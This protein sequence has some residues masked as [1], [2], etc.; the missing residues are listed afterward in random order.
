MQSSQLRHAFTY[1]V[2]C[3]G[4]YKYIDDLIRGQYQNHII[5]NGKFVFLDGDLVTEKPKLPDVLAHLPIG[6]ILQLK[7]YAELPK[8][9]RHLPDIVTPLEPYVEVN[10]TTKDQTTTQT[11]ICPATLRPYYYDPETGQEWYRAVKDRFGDNYLSIYNYYI[12]YVKK[13]WSFPTR[14][15]L[16]LYMAS[17]EKHKGYHTLPA[18]VVALTQDVIDN[19]NA[20]KGDMSGMNF[21]FTSSYSASIERRIQLEKPYLEVMKKKKKDI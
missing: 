4:T 1:L 21:Y 19:Y 10:Y 16:I 8:Y 14:D 9:E 17:R 12:A 7:E 11:S 20:I 3:R 18:N 2:K 6:I 15:Q 13:N 5:I